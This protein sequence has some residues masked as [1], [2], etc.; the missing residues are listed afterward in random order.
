MMRVGFRSDAQSLRFA[1]TRDIPYRVGLRAVGVL[2][3]PIGS[4]V[5]C[6]GENEHDDR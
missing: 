6:L 1:S 2:P 4:S 3:G 5:K